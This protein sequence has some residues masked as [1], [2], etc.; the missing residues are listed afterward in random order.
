[1]TAVHPENYERAIKQEQA[2]WDHFHSDATRYGVPHWLDLRRATKLNRPV[3]NPFDDPRVEHILRGAE[4][5]KF[6]RLACAAGHGARALDFG[7][8]MGWLSLELAR[9]G[10]YVTGLDLSPVSI[11][12]AKK[13]AETQQVSGSLQ[14]RVADLNREELGTAVYDVI[15]IWDVL[16]H[17]ADVDGVMRRLTQALKPGGQLLIWDHIGMQEKNLRFYRWFHYFVPADLRMYLNKL[18]RLLGLPGIDVF[19]GDRPSPER[20]PGD[21]IPA[22]PPQTDATIP[23]APFEHYAENQILPTLAKWTPGVTLET[24]LCF[25]MH[26]A[27]YHRLPRLGHYSLLWFLKRLDEWL[28][29]VGLLSGEYLLGQWTKTGDTA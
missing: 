16:H 20:T 19:R 25:V 23:D 17:L 15:V 11:Q 12:I 1:M 14:Y 21:A 29:Q 24:H 22:G 13:Y 27:H 2:F 4:K 18:R 9:A 3:Y 28:I 8:G 5:A 26:L 7:C 6:L 10:L